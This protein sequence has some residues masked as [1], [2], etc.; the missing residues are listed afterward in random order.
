M[1]LGWLLDDFRQERGRGGGGG[2]PH[3]RLGRTGPR[4]RM[5]AV[6]RAPRGGHTCVVKA[7]FVRAGK[8]SGRHITA[9]LRYIEERERGEREKER[10]FFD[11]DRRGIDRKEVQRAM[12]ENRGERVAMHKLILSPGDNNVDVREYTRES[13]EAL[14]ER[15]GHKL[16]WYAVIHENTDHHHAHVVVAGKIPDRD[17]EMERRAAREDAQWFD[18]TIDKM[19]EHD[20][21]A[22]RFLLGDEREDRREEIDPRDRDVVPDRSYSPEEVRWNKFLDKYE[23]EMAAREGA[24]E[25]GDVYLDRNDLKELRSAGNDYIHRDRSLERAWDR[26]LEREF[27]WEHDRDRDRDRERDI[28]LDRD[29]WSDISEH[30]ET[31][32]EM[33]RETERSYEPR[34]ERD[35]GDDE[36]KRERERDRGDDFGR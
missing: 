2:R 15:L 27:G 13:M 24:Q 20:K 11:R 35:R 17:R 16:D 3:I 26:E 18:K 10:D 33:H 29:R 8:D 36:A 12:L 21:E 22:L 25:R 1:T 14:E 5:Y 34:D 7:K 9:H 6:T 23:R 32:R 31:D 4:G 19:L 28:D 30:F